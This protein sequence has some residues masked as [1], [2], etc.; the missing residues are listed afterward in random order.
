[1]DG[2]RVT[3]IGMTSQRTRERLVARLSK[4]GITDPRVL[5]AIRQ[6]PRHLFVEEALA[7]RAYD[8]TAL[9]I[10]Y[11]QTIS[12]P[13]IVA[14]MTQLLLEGQ[15]LHKVLEVGTGSAYQAVVLA[16]L[17]Q[18][19]FSIE[20]LR[21]LHNRAHRL[22]CE[23]RLSNVRLRLGDGH[24]GWPGEA[25]FDG[26]IL[27]AAPLTIPQSLVE[28]LALGGRLVAPVGAGGNQ[29]MRVCERTEQGLICR[30]VSHVSFVPMKHGLG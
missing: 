4:A 10:G 23:L 26:I 12:Q 20:R 29:C 22:I 13:F 30:D 3:G 14:Q 27:T 8:D 28:Q 25:P 24:E 6:V 18:N 21:V 11:G 2:R 5:N 19:V 1:M 15:E 9:P 16:N 17:I 7:S